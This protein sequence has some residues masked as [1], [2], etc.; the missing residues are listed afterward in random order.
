MKHSLKAHQ[1]QLAPI[2]TPLINIPGTNT[3]FNT[4][5][6]TFV[7]TTIKTVENVPII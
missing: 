3:Y 4:F 2:I 6:I 1:T 5:E 7:P